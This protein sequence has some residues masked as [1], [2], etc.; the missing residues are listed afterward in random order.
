M[1]NPPPFPEKLLASVP[2]IPPPV[3]PEEHRGVPLK[4][5][6]PMIKRKSTVV[7]QRK[8]TVVMER[9]VTVIKNEQFVLNP[10]PFPE[11]LLALVP[12]IPP[13]VIPEEHRGVPLKCPPPI[14]IKE[15]PK[16]ASIKRPHVEIIPGVI[17]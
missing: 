4:C 15:M 7:R 8:S 3:I 6:P 11:K 13:P 12:K 14:K 9:K 16:K 5:P 1:L 2:K 10:L 17:P